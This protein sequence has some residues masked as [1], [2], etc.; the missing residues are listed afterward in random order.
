M[1][2]GLRPAVISLHEADDVGV[3]ADAGPEA[4]IASG[5]VVLWLG[6]AR[7]VRAIRGR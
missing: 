7:N 5:R 6:D 3:A 1:T 2:S 4:L